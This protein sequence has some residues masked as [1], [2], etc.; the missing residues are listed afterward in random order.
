LKCI[1]CFVESVL[2][3][4]LPPDFEALLIAPKKGNDKKIMKMLCKEYSYLGGEFSEDPDSAAAAPEEKN[5]LQNEKFFPFVFI[6]VNLAL[7]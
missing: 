5:A 7:N 6:D 1:Q 4:G 2:R 3:Y